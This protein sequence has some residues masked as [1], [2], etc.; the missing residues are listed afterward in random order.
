MKT[1]QTIES[2]M[3]DKC[4]IDFKK[5]FKHYKAKEDV[6]KYAPK[7]NY[8]R[9]EEK[10]HYNQEGAYLYKT[11]KLNVNMYTQQEVKQYKRVT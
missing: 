2:K 1:N 8:I 7:T 6:L 4:C 9:Y 3:L 10:S 11:G 5:E